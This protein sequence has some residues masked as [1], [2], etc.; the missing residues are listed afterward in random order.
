[1]K[2]YLPFAC[3]NLII[4]TYDIFLILIFLFCLLFNLSHRLVLSGKILTFHFPPRFFIYA[5]KH[6]FII[7]FHFVEIK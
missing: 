2:D 4:Y 3:L 1:M 6:N 5:D 7:S